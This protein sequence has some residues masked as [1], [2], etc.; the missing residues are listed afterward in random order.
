MF[1]TSHVTNNGTIVYIGELGNNPG[2]HAFLGHYFHSFCH[3][4]K[5]VLII[6]I[7]LFTVYL[8]IALQ[9]QSEFI[10]VD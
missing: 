9:S 3:Y 6:L 7:D 1:F 10:K 4:D 8:Y 5:I 2:P